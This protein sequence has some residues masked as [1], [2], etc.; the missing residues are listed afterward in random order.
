MRKRRRLQGRRVGRR[1][2]ECGWY[3]GGRDLANATFQMS[4]IK[5]SYLSNQPNLSFSPKPEE[6]A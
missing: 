4:L 1:L 2:W 6:F 3:C 5:I